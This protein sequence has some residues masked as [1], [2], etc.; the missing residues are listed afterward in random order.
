MLDIVNYCQKIPHNMDLM[1]NYCLGNVTM[2]KTYII[3]SLSIMY[4][5]FQEAFGHR[6]AGIIIVN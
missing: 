4:A 3:K 2:R 6:S 5:S 1:H